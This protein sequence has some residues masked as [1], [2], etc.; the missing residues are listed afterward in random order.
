VKNTIQEQLFEWICVACDKPLDGFEACCNHPGSF[1][2]HSEFKRG[3][4]SLS[5]GDRS[6]AIASAACIL[7]AHNGKA[8]KPIILAGPWSCDGD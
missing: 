7:T 1:V 8:I 2:G 3:R 4:H 5:F 6:A